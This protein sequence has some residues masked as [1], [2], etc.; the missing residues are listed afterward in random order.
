MQ[1]AID[2][3][4]ETGSYYLANAITLGWKNKN[5][6]IEHFIWNIFGFLKLQTELRSII[7]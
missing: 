2:E 5:S 6:K 1:N 3:V 7:V 4:Y